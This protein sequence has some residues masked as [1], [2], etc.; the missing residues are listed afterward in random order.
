MKT[1][2]VEY[3]E[4]LMLHE[5]PDGER[6]P[7]SDNAVDFDDEREDDQLVL[8]EVEAMEVGVNL[9]DPEDVEEE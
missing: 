7:T 2:S 9:D 3:L 1:L 5:R 4:D 6:D 8:D